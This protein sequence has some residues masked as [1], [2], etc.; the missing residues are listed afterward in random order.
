[1]SDYQVCFRFDPVTCEAL[2]LSFEE[3]IGTARPGTMRRNLR[4][5]KVVL[6]RFDGK[7]EAWIEVRD[8][9]KSEW[10]KFEE[11]SSEKS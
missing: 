7:R 3:G 4:R 10:R 2:G 8:N 6:A 5:A 11:E 1:M 9:R